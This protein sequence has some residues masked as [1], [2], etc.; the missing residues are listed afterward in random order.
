MLITDT[1]ISQHTYT[2]V[3]T[4]VLYS[5]WSCN[6]LYNKNTLYTYTFVAYR[7]MCLSIAYILHNIH[8]RVGCCQQSSW[9]SYCLALPCVSDLMDVHVNMWMLSLLVAEQYTSV[10][11]SVHLIKLLSWNMAESTINLH[12]CMFDAGDAYNGASRRI[13]STSKHM[14]LLFLEFFWLDSEL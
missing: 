9:M 8:E 3:H 12:F 1:Q 7:S 6:I 14:I 2:S 11:Y 5:A 13:Q 4:T 10:L